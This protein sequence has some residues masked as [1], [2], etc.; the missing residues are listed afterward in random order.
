MPSIKKL[1]QAAAGNAGGDNLYAE[2]VF[3]TYL[4]EGNGSTQTIS[5]GI[6]IGSYP[7]IDINNEGYAIGVNQTQIYNHT[8][9][10][11]KAGDF[12]IVFNLI[13][14]TSS[15]TCT[16]NGTTASILTQLENDAAYGYSYTIYTYQV[17]AGESSASISVSYGLGITT[18]LVVRGP[19]SVNL[20]QAMTQQTGSAAFG[21]NAT[22]GYTLNFVVDRQPTANFTASATKE[23]I[24]TSYT[25]FAFDAW[26]QSGNGT[27]VPAFTATDSVSDGSAGAFASISFEGDGSDAL[28]SSNG[29]GGLVWTKNRANAFNNFLYDTERGA[30]NYLISDSTIDQQTVATSLTSFNSNGFTLGA[31][32]YGNIVSGAAAVSWTFRKAEKFFDV[33][34]YTGNSTS[35]RAISHN[36]GATPGFIVV[37]RTNLASDWIVLHRN[38]GVTSKSGWLNLTDSFNNRD[39]AY[40]SS[41]P[42]ATSFYLGSSFEVNRTGDTYVAYLFAHDA[43]GF[44]DDGSE[45]IIKCGSFTNSGSSTATVNLG[46]E[47][48]FLM[49]KSTVTAQNWFIFDNMRGMPWSSGANYLNPNTSA[50]ETGAGPTFSLTATGFNLQGFIASEPYIYIAIRRPMKTPESGTEV[51]AVDG[52]ANGTA[53]DPWFISN[54]VTDMTFVKQPSAATG[55]LLGSRLTGTGIMATNSTAAESAQSNQNWDYMNGVYDATANASYLS[56]MFKRATGFFDVVAYTGTGV[57]RTVNHNLAAVPDLM[58]FKQR[59]IGGYWMVYPVQLGNKYL[60]LQLTNAVANGFTGLWNNASP[61]ASTFPLGTGSDCN[62]NGGTYVAYLFAT[63]A[64]VSKVGSYTG[65]AADLNV[66]CGFSAGAR[67]IL[68]KRTD[69]T[70]DWYVWDSARGIVAGNDPYLLL[71]S[72]AAEVTSTDYIDPLSSGFTVTS[73]APAALNAS[74]GTYIF[75]AIA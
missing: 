31:D 72:T 64:G 69:S 4:Y 27:S 40:F 8:H 58:I 50:A 19:T 12:V 1:L 67:F 70:G 74:G 10:N 42:D 3:S 38:D 52:L 48:Q 66:D 5:N 35:G 39:A 33:V 28:S 16:I 9:S 15:P 32:D 26:S 71:N 51:F 18:S 56:W 44:G 57:A 60:V 65:T 75:L 43:G 29:E 53:P 34:T 25:Y 45:N 6:N 11:L 14:S 24:D 59:D 7:I 49:V 68:I 73:S 20:E 2:D 47:P 62:Q 30:T 61:T 21:N 63:L 54:F 37:K 41:D 17:G 13:T 55:W 46:F 23:I 22:T 36:L